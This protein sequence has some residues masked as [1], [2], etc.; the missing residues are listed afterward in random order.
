MH[1]ATQHVFRIAS[2]HTVVGESKWGYSG[3]HSQ[4]FCRR[5]THSEALRVVAILYIILPVLMQNDSTGSA[6]KTLASFCAGTRRRK[7]SST[8]CLAHIFAAHRGCLLQRV[9]RRTHDSFS[10]EFVVLQHFP[11]WYAVGHG[12]RC[13]FL[14]WTANGKNSSPQAKQRSLCVQ[15]SH[16]LAISFYLLAFSF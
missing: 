7:T 13:R 5:H 2:F 11:K 3:I 6:I 12:A 8:C 16:A 15:Y 14:R 10:Q 1:I 9:W 4:G